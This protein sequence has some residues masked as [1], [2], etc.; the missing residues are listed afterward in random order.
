MK[1]NGPNKINF[2]FLQKNCQRP[3]DL[4]N[5]IGTEILRSVAE[6]MDREFEKNGP[7]KINFL[8]LEKNCLRPRDL[9]NVIGIEI[10]RSVAEIMDR[11]FENKMVQKKLFSFS[12]EE[13]SKA[14]GPHKCHRNRNPQI[15]S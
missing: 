11:E 2:L 5:V 15:R 9:I 14:W 8:F 7:K 10:L 4:I 3:G 13:L 12:I 6:I 1:R